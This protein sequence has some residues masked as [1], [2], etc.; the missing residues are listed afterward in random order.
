[1]VRLLDYLEPEYITEALTA[2]T[3]EGLLR[4]LSLPLVQDLS[5]ALKEKAIE[6]LRHR[7]ELQSTAVG[8]GVAIPHGK[9]PDFPQ[10]RIGVGIHPQGMDF[11]AVDRKPVT[12][13]FLLLA[14]PHE[15]ALYLHLLGIIARLIRSPEIRGDLTRART[16]KEIFEILTGAENSPLL[17]L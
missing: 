17:S 4:E 16:R 9:I 5:S 11:F 1:M 2:T 14:P 13:F 7:E 10:I 3:R 6:V 8:G 15:S 12:L